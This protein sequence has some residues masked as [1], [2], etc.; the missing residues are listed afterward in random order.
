M[1]TLCFC[2]AGL[3]D[4]HTTGPRP[5]PKALP[6]AKSCFALRVS[7]SPFSLDQPSLL[8]G[9]ECLLPLK[10]IL[11]PTTHCPVSL[12]AN[13]YVGHTH[14][15]YLLLPSLHAGQDPKSC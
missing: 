12:V 1:S 8:L 5:A 3:L 14:L 13:L 7:C 9:P 15:P 11:V 10:V 6:S 2:Q 4:I